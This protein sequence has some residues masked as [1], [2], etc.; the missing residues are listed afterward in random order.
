MLVVG[1]TFIWFPPGDRREHLFIVL[2]DPSSNNG[3]FAAFNLTK[4][5]G[6]PM[7]LTFQIGDHPYIN[8]YPTDVNFGDALIFNISKVERAIEF[9]QAICHVRMN[10]DLVEK[11]AKKAIGHPAIPEN[12]EQIVKEHWGL[13]F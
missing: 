11:I 4:S 2:T 10:P 5:R 6:G 1:D 3:D 8:K 12:V 13:G 7:A 9:G